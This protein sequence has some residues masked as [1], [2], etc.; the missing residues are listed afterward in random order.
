MTLI[1]V[2]HQRVG[3]H[4]WPLA[5]PER[6]YLSSIHRHNFTL[7]VEI[8]VTHDD[9]QIEFHDVLASLDDVKF[10]AEWHH[11]AP[12][13]LNRSCE[14]MAKVVLGE[15]YTSFPE[16]GVIN[17]EVWEDENCGARV[18]WKKGEPPH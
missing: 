18:E 12:A 13:L 4:R 3:Y 5:P 8:E 1:K 15:L 6:A 10:C 7:L 2:K 9:R 17:I 16:A 11:E 14:Q